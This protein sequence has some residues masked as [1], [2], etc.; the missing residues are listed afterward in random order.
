MSSVQA[1]K[2]KE[3]LCASPHLRKKKNGIWW[4]GYREVSALH[5]QFYILGKL[6]KFFVAVVLSEA[7]SVHDLV[8]ESL[9][10]Y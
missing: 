1:A 9:A 8:C 3:K 4:H 2:K 10:S 7:D 5:L 6:N